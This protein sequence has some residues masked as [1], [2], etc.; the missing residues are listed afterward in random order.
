MGCCTSSPDNKVGIEPMP[1]V[2]EPKN[3]LV[4]ADVL[5]PGNANEEVINI[6]E[7]AAPNRVSEVLYA[8]QK[9]KHLIPPRE[10]QVYKTVLFCIIEWYN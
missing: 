4:K 10:R 6:G 3:I 9:D 5:N 8:K 1:N 2:V 7:G